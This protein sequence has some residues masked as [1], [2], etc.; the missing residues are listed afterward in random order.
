MHIVILQKIKITRVRKL[1]MRL[2]FFQVYIRN[3]LN[4]KMKVRV[5]HFLIVHKVFTINDLIT[6]HTIRSLVIYCFS[7]ILRCR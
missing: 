1:Y 5:L 2:D 4:E 6:C 3:I 7:S